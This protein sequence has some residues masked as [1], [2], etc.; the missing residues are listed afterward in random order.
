[1]GFQLMRDQYVHDLEMHDVILKCSKGVFEEY[2]I[3]N[4]FLFKGNRLC[5]PK[6]SYREL[7]I[8]E[9]HGGGLAGHFGV[10]KTIEL[11]K[12]HLFWPKMLGDVQEIG[13]AHV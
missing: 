1:M 11:L 12:E 3:Q 13:R 10:H 9:A 8:R 7:L 5:V 2:T 4:G 6:G